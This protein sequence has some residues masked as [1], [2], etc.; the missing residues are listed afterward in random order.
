[1]AEQ[2]LNNSIPTSLVLA[3]LGE[4]F[5]HRTPW[6]RRLW[7]VGTN[8][9]LH[10]VIEY[11]D[12]C[13]SGAI[14]N[15][16][17]LRY[18]IGTVKRQ[19]DR[20]PGVAPLAREITS[21]LDALNVSSQSKIPVVTRDELEQLVRRLARDYLNNWCTATIDP[22]VEFAARALASHLLD[23]G[24]S[25]DHLHRWITAVAP[26]IMSMDQL[27]K[28]TRDMVARMPP[29]N[30][31]IFVPCAAPFDKSRVDTGRVRW[32]DGHAASAWIHECLPVNESRRHSGGFLLEIES[33]D[34]WSAV[35]DARVTVAR[36][37][38][39]AKVSSPSNDNIRLNGWARVAGDKRAYEIRPTPRQ[40]EI[41]SLVRQS[42]VYRFD[43]GLAP[44]TDDALELASYMES[45][46]AGAAVT[47]GWSAIEALLIRP[48]EGSHHLA[49][50]RLASLIACSLPRAELTPLAF[51][52]QE[53][54]D[55]ALAQALSES[56]ANYAKVQHVEAHLRAGNRLNLSESNDLAAQDRIVAI[57]QDPRIQL[58]Q[59]K[60]YVTESL[61]RLYNQRNTVAHAGSLR[62]AALSATIRTTLSLVG[63]GLD[64]I[65]HAQ[66]ESDGELQPLSLVARADVELRLVGTPGGRALS[67]L[68]E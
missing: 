64:R 54:T 4:F 57:I 19:V 50:D 43:D 31:T 30:Y 40:V 5:G 23:L 44:A 32:L 12:A 6:H 38:A 20:D 53:N 18:V 59:I 62:S 52:H 61:R 60:D 47:G 49:A 65:V 15:T 48:G 68:L 29:R 9:A 14:P 2:E 37:D 28:A 58:G 55:D 51:R 10:E 56:H 35:E 63:A 34:P 3:R 7:N 11:A 24:F 1:M 42:A 41:G 67:S 36:G 25:L 45:P 27:T 8:L 17:G 16:E 33:R 13:L 22:H 21:C 26:T 66:L 46:S 39:R